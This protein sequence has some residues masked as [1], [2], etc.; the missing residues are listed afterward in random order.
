VDPEQRTAPDALRRRKA[1]TPAHG[2]HEPGAVSGD[3]RLGTEDLER[4]PGTTTALGPRRNVVEPTRP[5]SLV[6]E[7]NDRA[8]LDVDPR[9]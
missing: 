1:R 2:L 3:L 5:T 4:H 9:L 7:T 6:A 8:V